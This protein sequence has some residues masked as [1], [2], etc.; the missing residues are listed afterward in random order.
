VARVLRRAFR[1]GL[2]AV[3]ASGWR[4]VALA[5]LAYA[6]AAVFGSVE[7]GALVLFV[8]VAQ[9]LALLALIRLLGA[10]RPVPVPAPPQVDEE[11]RRVAPPPRPGPPL[12]P[13]DRSPVGALRN[14]WRLWRPAVSLTGLHVLAGLATIFAAI[15]LSGGK[16]VDY[17]ATAQRVGVAPVG[18]LLTTFI[19]VAPQRVALEGDPRVLVAAAHSLRIARVAFGVLFLLNIP[20]PLLDAVAALLLP[21]EH[22][23]VARIAIVVAA[24]VVAGTIANLVTTAMANEVYLAGPRLDLPVDTPG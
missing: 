13:E 16:I 21:G 24:T 20:E 5:F 15:A 18:A 1:D 14:A 7:L 17:S 2:A 4:G 12:S 9:V 8:A 19:A 10:Y 6:P 22:P 23:P 3:R 11:G